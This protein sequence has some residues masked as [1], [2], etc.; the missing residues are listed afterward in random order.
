MR[1]DSVM[2]PRTIRGCNTSAL[3]TVTVTR[4]RLSVRRALSCGNYKKL[5]ILF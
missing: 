3:I 5:D 1:I 4:Q 2:C